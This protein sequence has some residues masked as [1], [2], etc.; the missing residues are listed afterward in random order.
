MT[1]EKKKPENTN[2]NPSSSSLSHITE[3]KLADND[4]IKSE[5]QLKDIILLN[6]CNN[7]SDNTNSSIPSI[8]ES[9]SV[10]K[11]KKLKVH[12]H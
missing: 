6:L 3:C 11:R 10:K 9:V 12:Q 4:I 2:A 8:S 5:S 7:E 1:D